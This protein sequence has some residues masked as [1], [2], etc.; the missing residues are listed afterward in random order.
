MGNERHETGDGTG[1]PWQVRAH[2]VARCT[3]CTG[4]VRGRLRRCSTTVRGG[5]VVRRRESA[6]SREMAMYVKAEGTQ[7]H[8]SGVSP[9]IINHT[10]IAQ[11]TVVYQTVFELGHKY[12]RPKVIHREHYYSQVK[13]QSAELLS[14]EST[15]RSMLLVHRTLRQNCVHSNKGKIFFRSYVAITSLA[16]YAKTCRPLFSPTLQVFLW[17]TCAPPLVHDVRTRQ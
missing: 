10:T 7:Y 1:W 2:A 11:A 16:T 14:P 4:R 13:C 6:V 17:R 5:R 9:T 15:V 8:F 12:E 3:I